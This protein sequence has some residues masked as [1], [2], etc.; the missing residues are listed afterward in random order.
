MGVSTQ[1]TWGVP[2][3]GLQETRELLLR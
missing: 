1:S 3:L 2:L